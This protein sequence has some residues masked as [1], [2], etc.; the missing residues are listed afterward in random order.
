MRRKNSANVIVSRFSQK[1]NNLYRIRHDIYNNFE[2][3][4]IHS[5]G[6]TVKSIID[7]DHPC[8]VHFTGIGGI[9]MSGFA[10]LLLKKGFDVSGS[11]RAPT[12]I[13]G[14]LEDL[15]AVITYGP[16][17]ADSVGDDVK[18]LVYTAAVSSDN[19]E[20]VRAKQLNIPCIERGKLAGE[21]MLHYRNNYSVAGTHGKT[22][23]TAMLS[24]VFIDA[25]F[26]P[27]VSVGGVFREIGGNFRIGG[28]DNFVIESC[29]YTDSFLN[30]HPTRA[31]ITNIEAEHLDYFGT[32]ERMR[33]S[34]ARFAGLLPADG[35]L[36]INSGIPGH[37]ELFADVKCPIV[38]YSEKDE[39]ADF[40]ARDISFD[41]YGC[42]SFTVLH[43][44][45][46]LGK[47]TLAVP[48]VHNVANA[49]GVAAMAFSEGIPFDVIAA[50]LERYHG[51]GRRFEKKGEVG[52][53]TV[54]DD[55]AHHPTE[56]GA[57]LEAAARYPHKTLW[58]VFQPHTY[59]RTAEFKNE[60]A[61]K[62]SLS[63][64][65][66]LTDIY[67]A[68][69]VNTYG[70]SSRDIA[71]IIKTRFGKE[72]YCFDDFGEVVDFLLTNCCP[73]DLLITMGAGDVVKIG[74]TL[75]GE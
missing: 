8:K 37:K 63:D 5:G 28:P 17:K 42:A 7:L 49:L 6:I 1:R 21:V 48:G 53:V 4:K 62:L 47:V 41:E 58:T 68:R 69:E 12:A 60:I 70:I 22:T 19:P 14:K 44:G 16:H 52:G 59:S 20:L 23:S 64:K 55:Y 10:E 9:S 39:N 3:I 38:T 25:G 11:D 31:I 36:A 2:K 51:I 57:T 61:E 75:L 72:V 71:D 18:L 43:R 35:L 67:A 46:A 50:G 74:E 30:F 54:I 13:T 73:G 29:E 32:E 34:F 45:S 15:G 27:T 24:T 56:I 65:I 66:V 33:E 26:D 40:A